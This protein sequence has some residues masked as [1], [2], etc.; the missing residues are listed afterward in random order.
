V[1]AVHSR[2]HAVYSTARRTAVSAV[3]ASPRAAT[4]LLAMRAARSRLSAR[5]APAATRARE[6][7]EAHLDAEQG[8]NVRNAGRKRD[9]VVA[10]RR[11]AG[12]L[13]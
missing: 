13:A 5:A 3:H 10:H 12:R 8:E 1:H 7:V 6:R 4:C 9:A 2:A 11:P